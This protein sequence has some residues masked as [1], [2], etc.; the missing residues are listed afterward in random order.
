MSF[1]PKRSALS[2][3]RSFRQHLIRRLVVVIPVFLLMLVLV[4]S[5]ILDT[6]YDKMTFNKL[7]WFN[8]TALVEHLRTRFMQARLSPVPRHCLVFIVNG[9]ASVNTPEMEVL[10]RYGNG[11]PARSSSKEAKAETLFHVRIN[12]TQQT[13]QTDAGSPGFFHLL[14]P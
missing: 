9:D 13:I 10:G 4:K 2:K 11:C 12:R 8:N 5:G 1:L 7:G 6:A 14:T 3:P